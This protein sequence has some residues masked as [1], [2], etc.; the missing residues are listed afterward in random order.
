MLLLRQDIL[1]HARTTSEIPGAHDGLLQIL[2]QDE[3]AFI[4]SGS[5]TLCLHFESMF[6][7]TYSVVCISKDPKTTPAQTLSHS[8]APAP[9]PTKTPATKKV[10]DIINCRWP[11]TIFRSYETLGGGAFEKWEGRGEYSNP[12]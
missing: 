4:M 6:S 2:K 1:L 12:L 5:Y 11:R 3:G 9:P 8:T 10:L 7:S